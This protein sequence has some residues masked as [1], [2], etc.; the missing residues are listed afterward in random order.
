M[1][2][3]RV[4]IIFGAPGSGKSESGDVLSRIAKNQLEVLCK[5]TTRPRRETDGNEIRTVERIS[6]NCD[7]RYSQYNFDYGFSTKEIWKYLKKDRSVAIIVNDIRT[8]KIL[9][10][11][12]GNLAHTIYVHSNI[13][14]EKIE[15]ISK[16]R[17][18]SENTDFLA[19]DIARRIEKI[20]TIH[21][22]YIENT[23]IF[24]S[25]IINIFGDNDN[26]RFELEV[27]LKQISD[28]PY[29][30]KRS[31]GSTAR[32]IVIAAGSYTGKDDLVN[33]MIQIEP[34]KTILYQKGT[35]RPKKQGDENELIHLDELGKKYNIRYKKNGYEYGLCK[36]DIWS[37]LSREKIVL[38]V[39]SDIDAIKKIKS[40]FYGICT[41]LYLH[42]NIDFDELKKEQKQLGK[43]E[44]RK[45]ESSSRELHSEYV[46]NMG[47]FDHVLLNTSEPEDLYD[48]AFN[49]LDY[50]LD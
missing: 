30:C 4:F 32:I 38:I 25:A 15:I 22:K 9:N 47:L 14:K 20:K 8:I 39:L 29:V 50:Y 46:S 7:I 37:G 45:R 43:S 28:Y 2:N 24:N 3:I 17:Y 23:R 34:E 40:L 16:K 12:F 41:V 18:P 31:F 6:K 49:I 48:Q 27:Q 35:T 21:R 26:S 10:K 19:K 36:N 11:K 44:F 1:N 13:N 42:A 33:A 5:E